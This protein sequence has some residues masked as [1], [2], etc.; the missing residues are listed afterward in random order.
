[1]DEPTYIRICETA[2]AEQ[3]EADIKAGEII[4]NNIFANDDGQRYRDWE[5]AA[6]QAPESHEGFAFYLCIYTAIQI[7][8]GAK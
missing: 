6:Y 4:Y 7:R 1:M 8:K 5:T 3:T 2:R